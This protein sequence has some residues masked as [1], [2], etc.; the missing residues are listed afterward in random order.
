MIM[1][2]RERKKAQTNKILKEALQRLIDGNPINRTLRKKERIKINAKNVED[3]A[4]VGRSALRHHPDVVKLINDFNSKINPR[5]QMG[6]SEMIPTS[7]NNDFIELQIKIDKLTEKL[8]RTTKNLKK[9]SKLKNEY[10]ND[11]ERLKLENTEL[12]EREHELIIALFEKV[13]IEERNAIFQKNEI[14]FKKT[15]IRK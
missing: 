2:I 8:A 7:S 10:R 9:V 12:R 1:G 13:P 14:N 15:L 6:N 5:S 11:I 4:G 3:E